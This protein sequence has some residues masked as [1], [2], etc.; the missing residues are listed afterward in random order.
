MEFKI[1]LVDQE[2][3]TADPEETGTSLLGALLGMLALFGITAAASYA[4]NRFKNLAGV[5]EDVSVPGI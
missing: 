4:F 2:V 3:D 1:P 5:S